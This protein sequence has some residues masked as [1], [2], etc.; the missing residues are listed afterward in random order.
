MCTKYYEQMNKQTTTNR[1]SRRRC[2]SSPWWFF[3]CHLATAQQRRVGLN[4]GVQYM[5]WRRRCLQPHL[6]FLFLYSLF[7]SNNFF[8]LDYANKWTN[9][10]LHHNT[11]T[12]T[13]RELETRTHLH[14]EFPGVFFTTTLQQ[15][16]DDGWGSMEGSAEDVC[17]FSPTVHFYL[18]TFL[19]TLLMSFLLDYVNKWTNTTTNSH[20][21]HN[22]RTTMNGTR[23]A[24]A[25]S[26]V[27]FYLLR[28]APNKLQQPPLPPPQ[29]RRSSPTVSFF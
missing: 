6:K 23:D 2:D 28:V 29:R 9:V 8:L 26:P 24:S 11:W 21:L 15:L 12:T 25:S 5:G 13:N 10:H 17:V 16:N 20:L 1:D 4:G 14:L 3:N 19:N 18:N 22:T 7:Y 27:S